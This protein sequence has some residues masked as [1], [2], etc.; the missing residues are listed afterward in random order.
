MTP[1]PGDGVANGWVDRPIGAHVTNL[2]SRL[3]VV[4]FWI[5]LVATVAVL[6]GWFTPW[7]VL[8][9]I[10]LTVAATWRF[11]PDRVRVDAAA[12]RG[13]LW[14]LGLALAW[15][16]A[17]WWFAAEILLVQRDGGFLTL[18][19]I[20]LSH[21]ADPD[22]PLR[23]AADVADAIPWV[24]PVSDAFWRDGAMMH[25]QGAKALP[26]LLGLAGWVG[27][28]N[29]LLGAN[30]I[31][32]AVA[33]LAVYDVG[34]RLISPRWAL[35]PVA[36]LMLCTP[37]LY[38]TRA[39]FTEPTN[40]VL[41]FG[42]LAVLWGAASARR[43]WPYALGGAM[44][45]AGALSRI[46]GAA[47]AVG[48]VGGL[49]LVAAG[50][51]D[52]SLRQSRIRGLV[53]A[54]LAAAAMVV[55]GY[56]DLRVN[57]PDYLANH[58]SMYLPLVAMLAAAVLASVVLLLVTRSRVVTD[59]LAARADVLGRIA[60]WGMVAL[61]V[62]LAS[63]PLWTTA[64][65]IPADTSYAWFVEAIQS[66]AGVTVDGT[67]SY[68]EST[69][70]WL[71]W[72]FGPVTVAL[73]AVGAALLAQ[74]A[75]V[76]RRPELVTLLVVLGVPS[77]LYLVRPSITPDQIWAMRR[78][79]PT[80][81]PGLLLCAAW[82]L[83]HV[84]AT[85]TRSWARVGAKIAV[86][87]MVLAPMVTWGTLVVA[88]E[89]GGRASELA[90][91]CDE[92]RG[93]KV[94][95]VRRGDPPLVP[96]LRIMCDADAVEL[97]GD[98]SADQ[99]AEIRAAWGGEDVF[100]VSYSDSIEPWPADVGSTWQTAMARWPTSLFPEL[101]PVRFTSQIWLGTVNA[102]GSVTPVTP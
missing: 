15:V 32:G 99:L 4:L 1:R 40:I 34:R 10:G 5:T 87:L 100:V 84:L 17:N 77:L 18:E 36:A 21:N 65:G 72:Y 56:L 69:V 88:T 70:T 27:G 98:A 25:A 81:I 57:S 96:T 14:A 22:I 3:P 38:F 31:V 92:V 53:V 37:F 20:W 7:L 19:G 82:L 45:G 76:A 23:T 43:M 90:A 55:L 12:A 2:P 58:A 6:F 26:A 86:V 9:A 85:T 78:F 24:S 102:D 13:A 62:L 30:L 66:I 74:R 91:L 54:T 64:H 16:V 47:A 67:R 75:V 44:V 11:V 60:L 68:D 93:G 95:A 42:G 33:L 73:A 39:P 35:L 52:R 51:R 83:H 101:S 28:Q 41:T 63:R 97:R 8:P 61:S 50:S 80:A 71:V 59:W 49:A 29:G 46:D 89:Y 48:L 79:L 94:I